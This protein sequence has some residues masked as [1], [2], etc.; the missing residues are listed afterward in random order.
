MD[1]SRGALENVLPFSLLPAGIRMQAEDELVLVTFPPGALAYSIDKVS[2]PDESVFIV[3]SGAFVAVNELGIAKRDRQ[4]TRGAYFGAPMGTAWTDVKSIQIRAEPGDSP[5]CVWKMNGKVLARLLDEHNTRF[6]LALASNLRYQQGVFDNFL[7]FR[8]TVLSAIYAPENRVDLYQIIHRYKQL[9]PAI[10]TLALD[11]VRID[12]DAWTYAVRRLPDNITSVYSIVLSRKVINVLQVQNANNPVPV[13]ASEE[14]LEDVSKS[15]EELEYVISKL[16][17]GKKISTRLRRRTCWEVMPGKLF[18]LLRE[19]NSD[20]FDILTNLCIHIVEMKKLRN[21]LRPLGS[22]VPILQQ[23]LGQLK[24]IDSTETA[25]FEKNVLLQTGRLNEQDVCGLQRV[26]SDTSILEKTIEMIIHHGDYDVYLDPAGSGDFG[27]SADERWMM[28]VR[29][30][31]NKL[32][33]VEDTFHEY[34]SIAVVDIISSNTHSVKNL[35]SP[36][37]HANRE[38]IVEWGRLHH[39]E[40]FD[41]PLDNEMDRLYAIAKLYLQANPIEKKKQEQLELEAGIVTLEEREVT[42]IS[43]Q[44]VD[45][46]KLKSFGAPFDPA[47]MCKESNFQKTSGKHLLVNIDYCFGV[48]AEHILRLLVLT[49]AKSIRSVNILGKA[50]GLVGNRGDIL[51]PTFVLDEDTQGEIRDVD[52]SDLDPKEL[53]RESGRSV[54]VGPIITIQGTLLQNHE[55][56]TFYE[57]LWHATGMEM[58]ATYYL[59]AINEGL[60]LR[61]LDD[62]LKTRLL[63]YVSDTP[64]KSASSLARKLTLV[65][66]IPPLY[67]ITRS[68]LGR[69]LNVESIIGEMRPVTTPVSKWGILRAVVRTTFQTQH[70]NNE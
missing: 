56:L 49:F 59:R 68:L 67:A 27:V 29:R 58:E 14:A 28:R 22:V 26:W 24:Y 42:G 11:P 12:Y 23:G 43:V 3:H 62:K 44:L 70:K 5:S 46:N 31:A 6:A 2:K 48:Q 66:G 25:A 61:I 33:D 36:Y 15:P 45:L 13:Y 57:R 34:E 32:L 21:A 10:H 60:S 53:H 19:I 30:A 7:S 37:I 16:S 55:L 51:F 69:V 39:P 8:A 1:E 54:H 50:G 35:I 52:N 20:F 40:V 63:Y 64:L 18:V 9:Q 4:L 65:E 41:E 17:P 38:K 47:F